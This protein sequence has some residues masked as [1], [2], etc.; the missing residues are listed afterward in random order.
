MWG[1]IPMGALFT[2]I[3]LMLAPFWGPWVLRLAGF[4]GITAVIR[5][6]DHN[7][8]PRLPI[9]PRQLFYRIWHWLDNWLVVRAKLPET[10]ESPLVRWQ[11]WLGWIQK[12]PRPQP[13]PPSAQLVRV[14][15]LVMMGLLSIVVG[16]VYIKQQVRD[17]IHIVERFYDDLDFRRFEEA[18]ARLDPET[19]PSFDQYLLELSVT[20]GL[21]A[22]YGKLESIYVAVESEEPEQ[23]VVNVTTRLITALSYYDTTKQHTLVKRD[24]TWYILPDPADVTIPPDTFF[25]KGTVAWHAAGRRRVSVD[26]TSFADILDRPEL[27]ILSARLVEIDGRFSVVGEL[28]NTDAD[29]AD[30]TVSAHMFDGLGEEVVWYNAHQGMIHKLFPKEVTPFRV[31][32]E[33]VAGT[34]LADHA[35]IEF[36]PGAIYPFET[37]EMIETFEVYAQA[38]VTTEDLYRDVG[39]Q[40]I[41]I[42]ADED[43]RFHLTGELHNAGTLEA[44]IP[45]VFI[46]YYDEQNR[47]VWVDDFFVADAVRPQRTV[48]LDLMLTPAAEVTTL[49]DNGDAYA[50]TL[51]NEVYLDS[52]WLERTPLPAETGYASMRISVHYFVGIP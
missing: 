23:M 51:D 6:L 33:G 41:Q 16:V 9:T 32:F 48:P 37:D 31:D 52:S 14:G 24:D 42:V 40:N 17:P 44:T 21:V 5:R 26:T 27:Q 45:H 19:R 10:D 12:F 2:G 1:T 38:V 30:V 7:V 46:T 25:R 8:V 39:V 47:V 22:S 49:L 13:A 50:N 36:E 18:Y 35:P 11:V 20:N 28:I 34:A 29:P 43:G 3:S 4:L 15:L